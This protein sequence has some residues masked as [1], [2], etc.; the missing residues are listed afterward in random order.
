MAW[1]HTGDMKHRNGAEVPAP[2]SC[3][4]ALRSMQSSLVGALTRIIFPQCLIY[5][6]ELLV[7]VVDV[8]LQGSGIDEKFLGITLFALVPNTTEFMN[9]IS[10]ALNSNISLRY[11]SRYTILLCFHD[12]FA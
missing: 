10:F 4:A 7:E 5:W 9:A 2:L 12:A 6:A 8:V 1:P 3:L 11:E